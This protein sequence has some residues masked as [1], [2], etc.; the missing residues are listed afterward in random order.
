MSI[1]VVME[2]NVP[3]VGPVVMGSLSESLDHLRLAGDERRATMP[4]MFRIRVLP[5]GHGDCLLVEYGSENDVHR[6]LID[7]RESQ[8]KRCKYSV[9]F[10]KENGPS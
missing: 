10:P 7:Q 9:R 4:T 5:A 6:D 8:E 2:D 3:W 1:V